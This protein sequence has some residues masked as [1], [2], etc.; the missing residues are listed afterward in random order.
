M[1]LMDGGDESDSNGF[2]CN[3]CYEPAE[4]DPIV[5]P[6]GHLYCWPCLYTWLHRTP[7]ASNRCPCPVCKVVIEQS[8]LIPLY[9]I[10]RSN[11]S[12]PRLSVPSFEIPNRPAA[13][14][15]TAR[16]ASTASIFVKLFCRLLIRLGQQILVTRIEI[17][18]DNF[19][20]SVNRRFHGS[21]EAAEVRGNS[22]GEGSSNHNELR[23]GVEVRDNNGDGSRLTSVLDNGE[24]HEL[25]V[26]EQSSDW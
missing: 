10:G 21:I 8:R 13:P 11:G 9:G 4:Q 14:R 20:E 18:S 6:C 17:A 7:R 5:T 12:D 16:P 22:D 15:F 3:I 2:T 25:L 1:K 24:L 23:D 26:L 19:V